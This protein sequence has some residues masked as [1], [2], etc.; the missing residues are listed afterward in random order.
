[1]LYSRA[2]RLFVF[3]L[4]VFLPVGEAATAT[5]LSVINNGLDLRVHTPQDFTECGDALVSAAPIQV[6]R[7]VFDVPRNVLSQPVEQVDKVLSRLTA[8]TFTGC[9]LHM[10]GVARH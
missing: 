2:A 10:I 3:L 1:M 6:I 9:W 5:I 4:V 7:R 8:V